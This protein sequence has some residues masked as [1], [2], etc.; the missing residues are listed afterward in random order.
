MTG[1]A[2]LVRLL[3]AD[4]TGKLME[5]AAEMLGYKKKDEKKDPPKN[6]NEG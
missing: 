5:R 3:A 4:P 6:K 2:D 1:L